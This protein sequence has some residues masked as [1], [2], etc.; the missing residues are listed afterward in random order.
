MKVIIE[1]K[2][3][4]IYKKPDYTDKLTN[5]VTKGKF[6]LQLMSERQLEDG[7]T[8]FEMHDISIPEEKLKIYQNQI[9]KEVKVLCGYFTPDNTPVKFYGL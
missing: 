2:L 7:F 6:N 4:S 1:A 3:Q 9:G 8:K 5:S